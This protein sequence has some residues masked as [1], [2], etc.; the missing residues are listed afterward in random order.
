MVVVEDDGDSVDSGNAFNS[1]IVRLETRVTHASYK[2]Y[3][4]PLNMIC[5][6]IPLD[7]AIIFKLFKE[8]FH[9]RFEHDHSRNSQ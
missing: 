5:S 7:Y 4:V 8:R 2:L 1:L 6:E 3:Y 9:C